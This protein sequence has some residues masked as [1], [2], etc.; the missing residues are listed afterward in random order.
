M[1]DSERLCETDADENLGY[2]AGEIP[3]GYADTYELLRA[4]GAEKEK[5]RQIEVRIERLAG[6]K[7]RL[8][9]DC[10]CHGE[11]ICPKCYQGQIDA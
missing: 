6:N 9:L 1:S 4:L 11:Y 8:I 10:D 2:E 5:A 7:P 3:E